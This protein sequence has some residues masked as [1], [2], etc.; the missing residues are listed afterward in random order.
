MPGSY[1][2][3][4]PAFY[5]ATFL[6]HSVIGHKFYPCGYQLVL[7]CCSYLLWISVV[8]FDYK[9]MVTW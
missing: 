4:D 6:K 8:S 7:V 5:N 3:L 2:L 1:V 9:D